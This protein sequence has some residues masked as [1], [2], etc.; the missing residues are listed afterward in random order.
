MVKKSLLWL[1]RFTFLI[2]WLTIIVIASTVLLLRYFFLPHIDDYKDKITSELSHV[3]GQKITI[4]KIYAS[5]DGMRPHLDLENVALYDQENR[6]ALNLKSVETSLS[7]LS[8]PLLSPRVHSLIVHDPQL[9]IRREENGTLYVAGIS[10]SGP[11]RPELPNWLLHQERIDILNASIVWQ[12]DLKHAP[13]LSLEKLNFSLQSPPWDQLIGRH[14]FGLTAVPSIKASQPID[15]RG[16]FWGRD[17]SE[18]DQWHGTI[19]GKA[20]GTDISDWKQWIAM[21]FELQSGVGAARFWLDLDHGKPVKITADVLLGNVKT[22]LGVNTPE[23]LFRNLSGRL[24]WENDN[25]HQQLSAERL[26]LVTND[27]LDMQNGNIQVSSRPAGNQ[28]EV[29]GA[30]KLN[31]LSLEALTVFSA[32]LPISSQWSQVLSETSPKGMLHDV[33]I[34]WK[35]VGLKLDQYSIKSRLTNIGVNP[36]QNIPGFNGFDGNVEADQSG[37]VLEINSKNTW[38]NLHNVLRTPILLDKLAGQVQWKFRGD[39]LQVDIV[40][41]NLANNNL[42][43]MVNAH[44]E[45]DPNKSGVID[46]T[47]K[48]DK[49]D[50]KYAGLYYPTI[51][52]KDTLHW[53]DT[54]ILSGTG[55]DVNVVLKGPLIDFPFDKTKNGLFQVKAKLSNAQLQYGSNWPKLEDI[56]LNMLFEGNKMELTLNSGHIFGNQVTRAKAIIPVLDADH[57]ELLI[58]GELHGDANEAIKFLN[59]SPVQNA[60]NHFTDDMTATGTGKLVLGLH[61]PLDDSINTKVTGGYTLINASLKGGE[62]WPSLDHINGRLEFTERS[63]KAQNVSALISGEATLFNIESGKDGAMKVIANGKLS[64]ASVRKNLPSNIAQN[65][66]GTI[67]WNG[68]INVHKHQAEFTLT[69]SLAGLSSTL[70]EPFN[71]LAGTNWPLLIEKKQQGNGQDLVSISVSNL[72]SA[73]LLR[74]L[75]GSQTSIDRGEV[76]FGGKA[77]LP[78]QSG[79]NIRG[80]L[81]HIDFD[82]WQEMLGK[83][84]TTTTFPLNNATL[85]INALDISGRKINSLKLNLK[86]N[87]EGFQLGLQSQEMNGDISWINKGNGKLIGRFKSLTIP[88]SLNPNKIAE[89]NA[90]PEDASN[91]PALDIT[92]ENFEYAQKKLGKL[93]LVANMDGRNWNIEKLNIVNP[94][95]IIKMDGEWRSWRNHPNT[96]IN[97]K[98]SVDDV[99]KSL[100]R[101]GYPGTIK[102][103][104]GQITGQLNWAG[105]PHEFNFSGLSGHLLVDAKQGQF[106]K[107]QPG[108]GRL[109][110]VV[111][112]QNL[113]KRLLFDFGDVFNSGFAFDVIGGNLNIARGIMRSDDFKLEGSAAKVAI[114]GET[115]LV[116]ES[117]NFH[118]KVMPAV[119]DSI[120][121]AA[122]AG[123]PAVG[124]AAILAQKLFKDPLNKL[125]A[126]EYDIGG[127]WDDPQEI[128]GSESKSLLPAAKQ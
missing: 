64:E 109:L 62:D 77:E 81:D 61:V 27:G 48:F 8:I 20:E 120:S 32:Y 58:D 92:A 125:A 13:P 2:L 113:P 115:D 60:I 52:N 91:Y 46:L 68:E 76:Y 26:R 11:S 30:V 65:I 56:A 44:F 35:G 107:A 123:G 112:L 51:L 94:E 39:H 124:V 82:A 24:A 72:L 53:L 106:L 121:L 19:Y 28:T 23:V 29:T 31:E 55:N 45:K 83:N 33:E 6:V 114:N 73:K 127:T 57:P 69:S 1:Y 78:M 7:W 111:S 17:I 41:L 103:G 85:N 3:A 79:L 22:K 47:G 97:I 100:D 86:P 40:K 10:M 116:K 128:N 87:S 105:S 54:S 102:G 12:D 36:Y 122:F 18:L 50:L 21:P 99:G 34:G 42:A 25:G 118:I 90:T 108:V 38:L 88:N 9:T 119:S 98:W 126:Y 70:P 59:N 71:K 49:I 37:G 96:K 80:N 66:H 89:P 4:G 93:E 67:D 104:N 5:W 74:N 101:M 14:R 75:T 15:L 63:M 84:K 43:G 117:M 110:S 16:S 95:G